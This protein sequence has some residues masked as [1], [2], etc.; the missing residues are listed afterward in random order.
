MIDAWTGPTPIPQ[1]FLKHE[2]DGIAQLVGIIKDQ[3]TRLREVTSNL[4]RSAGIK[5]TTLGMT[6]TSSLSVEGD[7]TT[8][9][10]TTIGGTLGVTGPTTLGAP[11]TVSGTLGVT[12]VTT[13]DAD[14]T[15]SGSLNVT[16]PM[17]VTGTLSLPAGIINNDA[18]AH[19]VMFTGTWNDLSNFAIPTTP[20]EVI[21][22]SLTIP[23]GFTSMAF[24]V[25]GTAQVGNTSASAQFIY[26]QPHRRT[27]GVE[28]GTGTRQLALLAPD[29]WATIITPYVYTDTVA[30]GDVVD[31]ALDVNAGSTALAAHASNTVRIEVS[32]TLTR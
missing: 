20:T 8:T 6:I 11:T 2:P 29:A 26:L 24:T 23:A 17:A 12:G 22:A 32:I 13:L 9:G 31:F 7:L 3:G 19:P 5:L 14:T 1:Q 15:V 27:N 30:P 4:L 16:G 25:I 21:V 10:A 18:L 28:V